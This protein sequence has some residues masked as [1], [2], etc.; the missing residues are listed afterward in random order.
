MPDGLDIII[1]DDD[2][3]VAT[4]TS[5]AVKKFYTWGKVFVFTDIEEA[6]N[7]SLNRHIGVAIFIVDVFLNGASGFYFLDAVAKKFPTA[8]E[9]TIMITGNPSD[10]VVN[11]CVASNVNY[12]L[13]KPIKP[14]TLQLAVR[15]ITEK[16]LDF[17][18]KLMK[19]PL[20]AASVVRL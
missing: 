4:L 10:D 1:V 19:Y 18:K 7:Y 8:H 20:L 13:E 5:I 11:M 2:P 6:I 3:S 17:A 9:D 12:L 16:Y 15:A 14:Y